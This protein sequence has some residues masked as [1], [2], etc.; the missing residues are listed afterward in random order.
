MFR[1]PEIHLVFGFYTPLAYNSSFHAAL[2]HLYVRLVSD[3]LTKPLYAAFRAGYSYS[4][5][6]TAS[7]FTLHFYGYSDHTKME[8]FVDVVIQQVKQ[9]GMIALISI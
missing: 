9:I 4:L 5:G 6:L 3:A 2:I 8:Q 7:G 1:T